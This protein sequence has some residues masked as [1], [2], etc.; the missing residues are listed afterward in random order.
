M[1][2]TKF[3]DYT[4]SRLDELKKETGKSS[5]SNAKSNFNKALKA[6][7]PAEP[8][9]S[10]VFTDK[11]A[12]NQYGKSFSEFIKKQ[13]RITAQRENRELDSKKASNRASAAKGAL[14]PIFEIIGKEVKTIL[15]EQKRSKESTDTLNLDGLLFGD[16]FAKLCRATWP[17][18][19]SVHG[20][21]VLLHENYNQLLKQVY[22]N[23][24]SGGKVSPC[25]KTTSSLA[26]RRNAL[27]HF[28][29]FFG[30][31]SG[32]LTKFLP[33]PYCVIDTGAM[34]ANCDTPP[35]ITIEHDLSDKTKQQFKMLERHYLR[36]GGISNL[37]PSFDCQHHSD[38]QHPTK[39][40]T[41][42]AESAS[43]VNSENRVRQ[44]KSYQQWLINNAVIKTADD[45][46]LSFLLIENL[47][48]DYVSDRITD[49]AF[50]VVDSFLSFIKSAIQD[51]DGDSGYLSLFHVPMDYVGYT[52]DKKGFNEWKANEK[53]LRK[54]ITRKRAFIK[55]N[56]E[57]L[58]GSRNVQWLLDSR[59]RKSLGLSGGVK[60]G[61]A[62]YMEIIKQLELE[63]SLVGNNLGNQAPH[64]YN[65]TMVALFMR[66]MFQQPMRK[67]N[68]QSLRLGS[69]AESVHA[70]YPLIWKHKG[71]YHLR[72][73]AKFVK[74]KRLLETDFSASLTK[75][76]DN[77]LGKRA[78]R[79]KARNHASDRFFCGY[80]GGKF[81]GTILVETTYRACKVLWPERNYISWGFNP[82]ALRHFVATLY[83][84]DNPQD[85]Y[86]L[87]LL[88]ADKP[89]TVLATYAKPD[90]LG[91]NQH[92]SSWASQYD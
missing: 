52:Q 73:P 71:C 2:N 45:F 41:I 88:L 82:H 91:V 62:D 23:W 72:V 92:H 40:W 35:Q 50:P 25:G 24:L 16:V 90:L 18:V 49:G 86:R 53:A 51:N 22:K 38:L 14:K 81:L 1:E 55:D 58:D 59:Y 26:S 42:N 68:W 5:F 30:V 3:I 39:S 43:C 20:L 28:E 75:H 64:G 44:I 83:L 19:T 48:E 74:N 29:L 54:M 13:D 63:G 46:D 17:D 31:P 78:A 9:L 56:A 4:M 77:Y 27:I 47:V 70:K 67:G 37:K 21:T 84:A 15:A 87:A 79:L 76:I 7:I 36:L 60:E 12:F 65:A 57:R 61:V 34:K 85:I 6:D 80:S 66:L 11:Q 32:T 10:A 8:S 89:E 69:H 33:S